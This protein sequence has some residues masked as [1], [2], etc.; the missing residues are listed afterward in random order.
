MLS[1]CFLS[2]SAAS[3][4]RRQ[5]R[6]HEPMFEASDCIRRRA[7][8]HWLGFDALLARR[9]FYGPT[10]QEPGHTAPVPCEVVAEDQLLCGQTGGSSLIGNQAGEVAKSLID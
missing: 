9:P 8:G 7:P 5:S 2:E 1:D 6:A 3:Q 4:R 10:R